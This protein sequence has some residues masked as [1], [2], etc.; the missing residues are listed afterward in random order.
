MVEGSL[1]G[2]MVREASSFGVPWYLC[3]VKDA[4]MPAV[5]DKYGVLLL[6]WR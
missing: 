4:A 1:C 5:A 3:S 2:F 6:L